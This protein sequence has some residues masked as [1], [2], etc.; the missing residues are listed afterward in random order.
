MGKPCLLPSS[1]RCLRVALSQGLATGC[2]ACGFLWAPEF[3]SRL[4][5]ALSAGCRPIS[6]IGSINRTGQKDRAGA[7]AS[8]SPSAG[9][10]APCP[11]TA[12]PSGCPLE[13]QCSE[14]SPHP[15]APVGATWGAPLCPALEHWW[16]KGGKRPSFPLAPPRRHQQR[17]RPAKQGP[18]L[19]TR[20]AWPQPGS[21]F[22]LCGPCQAGSPW[23]A[24]VF[25]VTGD[26][27]GGKEKVGLALWQG[28]PPD[29]GLAP[30]GKGLRSPH[31]CPGRATVWRRRCLA[32]RFHYPQALASRGAS[33]LEPPLLPRRPQCNGLQEG[34]SSCL[35]G[36][37]G[38]PRCKPALEVSEQ[39]VM[40]FTQPRVHGVQPGWP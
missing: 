36:Q 15:R 28:K 10:G 16:P 4:I 3:T 38:L 1:L 31:L 20:G 33:G 21:A 34:E 37:G 19:A 29:P 27:I 18:G 32:H 12:L 22:P 23:C 17:W 24:P 7:L 9:G 39:G 5:A 13:L 26:G 2:L 30:A 8:G 6:V 11:G 35:V 14:P 25:P 40:D